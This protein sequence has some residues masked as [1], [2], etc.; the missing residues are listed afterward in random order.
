VRAVGSREKTF[1]G[2]FQI[3]LISTVLVLMPAMAM[4]ATSSI[5]LEE[6]PRP[7]YFSQ[8]CGAMASASRR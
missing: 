4:A 2:K 8:V 7:L 6:R 1:M 5:P 3:G